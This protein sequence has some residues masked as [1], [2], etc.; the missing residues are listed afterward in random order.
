MRRAA[1]RADCTAGKS[2]AT[3]TPIIAITTKSSTSVKPL[4]RYLRKLII[5]NLLFEMFLFFDSIK[6]KWFQLIWAFFDAGFKDGSRLLGVFS[7]EFIS[8]VT[9]PCDHHVVVPRDCSGTVVGV[10]CERAVGP[11][12]SP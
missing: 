9:E 2:S 11:C 6:P 8:L 1:S 3:S 12:G 7:G 5:E 10:Q 4:R